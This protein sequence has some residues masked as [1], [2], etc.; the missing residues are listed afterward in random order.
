MYMAQKTCAITN[1][2]NH[3][4]SNK[5]CKL[6]A[7]E[8]GQEQTNQLHDVNWG[9]LDHACHAHHVTTVCILFGQ[10]VKNSISAGC[11]YM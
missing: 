11:R 10:I 7:T 4:Y 2:S 1:V 3:L 8:G 9:V 5:I 6:L